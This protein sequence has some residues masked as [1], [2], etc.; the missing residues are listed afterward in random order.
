MKQEEK[1]R[2]EYLSVLGSE[3]DE[4]GVCVHKGTAAWKAWLGYLRDRKLLALHRVMMLKSQD[5][6]M[7]LI[8]EY[9]PG[10]R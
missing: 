5:A 4:I 2:L 3:T 9:P 8:S 10:G 1:R 6:T 7:W